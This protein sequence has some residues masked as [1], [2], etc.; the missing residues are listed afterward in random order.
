[1]KQLFPL[2]DLRP[3]QTALIDRLEGKPEVVQRLQEV[4]L[5][6]GSQVEMV[7]GGRPC[8]VRLGGSRLCYRDCDVTRV[9][10][11]TEGDE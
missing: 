4:G 8:I 9:L 7:R 3:G 10:V 11:R 2:Q 6:C 1:M 5:R